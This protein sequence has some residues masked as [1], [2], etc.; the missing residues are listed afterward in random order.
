[1]VAQFR[2]AM[3]ALYLL[4]V[5]IA[6]ICLVAIAVVIPYGVYMRYIANHAASWPEPMAILLTIVLT[7]F[8]G[9]ACYRTG[10]HMRVTLLRT[11]MPRIIEKS[12]TLL[13]ELLMA[14]L[15]VF[16]VVHGS[17]LVET[18]WHQG[19]AEFPALKVGISYLPI[20]IG[21][22]M[23]LLFVVEYI[24]IGPPPTAAVDA[25]SLPIAE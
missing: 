13:A 5:F 9:A 24:L 16:M 17:G 15:A 7:F 10:T 2:R 4:C 6:G 21:G 19:V 3:D 25:D 18:T 20:P 14:L 8:G 1:M 22:A 11:S 12:M 23:L